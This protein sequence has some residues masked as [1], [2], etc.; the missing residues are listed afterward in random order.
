[1]IPVVEQVVY[2]NRMIAPVLVLTL[3][4]IIRAGSTKTVGGRRYRI[5]E[6]S[7][8]N[9]TRLRSEKIRIRRRNKVTHTTL[10]LT[11]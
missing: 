11:D 3:W 6:I 8:R 5:C 10:S 4:L 7:I 1:M 2:L 9:R